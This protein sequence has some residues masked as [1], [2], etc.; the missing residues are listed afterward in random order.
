MHSTEWCALTLHNTVYKY[1]IA[2]YPDRGI[3][4][5]AYLRTAPVFPV[6]DSTNQTTVMFLSSSDYEVKFIFCII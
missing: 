5:D 2:Q 4:L 3:S 1:Y 6:P